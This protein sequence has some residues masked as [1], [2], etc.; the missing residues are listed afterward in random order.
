[1]THPVIHGIPSNAPEAA[2]PR[3]RS[4][5]DTRARTIVTIATLS[6]SGCASL[7][8]ALGFGAA[9][10]ADGTV[11]VTNGL[12]QA[13]NVYASSRTGIGEVFVGNVPA[14]RTDTIPTRGIAPGQTVRLRAAAISGEAQF[15]QE[16]VVVGAGTAWRIP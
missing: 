1:M 13:V 4:R 7:G 9:R 6:V 11:V 10:S 8:G 2:A 15:Q 14:G 12:E 5:T 3:R 16:G